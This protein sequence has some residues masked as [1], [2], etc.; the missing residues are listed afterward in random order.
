[1]DK[2][3]LLA[4]TLAIVIMLFYSIAMQ[5]YYPS[6]ATP[7]APASTESTKG[8]VSQTVSSETVSS[9]NLPK[10]SD[11]KT[12]SLQ[13]EKA[14]YEFSDLGGSLKSVNINKYNKLEQKTPELIYNSE[15]AKD[16]IFSV[17]GMGIQDGSKTV[18]YEYSAIDSGIEYTLRL[19]NG[20]EV[21]KIY[22]ADDNYGLTLELKFT[23]PAENTTRER[24][25]MVA[26]SNLKVL[27]AS[28]VRFTEAAFSF[29][30][31]QK[32]IRPGSINKEAKI[33]FGNA[34][35]AAIQGKY[36]SLVAKPYQPTVSLTISKTVS[37]PP[38]SNI[39]IELQQDIEIA[40]RSSTTHKFLLY[41]GP[42]NTDFMALHQS[43]IENSISYGVFGDISKFLLFLLNSFYKVSHNYGVSIILLALLISILLYPLTLKSLKSMKQMQA[44][45]PKVDKL[46]KELKDNPQK[47][48]KEMLELY[49]KYKVNPFGGCLPMLLQMPIFIAL[50]QAF[51]RAIELK[52]AKF[53]WI[54]DL[55]EPDRAFFLPLSGT[56]IPVNILPILMAI[57]M[58][59][60]Q[61]M[62][63][64][65]AR[66]A[67]KEDSIQQ[68]QKMMVIMMPIL[69]GFIFYNMPSGLVLYWFLNTVIMLIQQLRIKSSFHVETEGQA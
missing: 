67:D 48:N 16:A 51:I 50:Y 56:P 7:T 57:T 34:D 46:R 62:T 13:A 10:L 5:K 25:S 31:K 9:A 17:S 26:V 32:R 37:Q 41:S 47:L 29:G 1:M 64:S 54:K 28:D 18:S 14:R 30:A 6:P 53:L 24:Y 63:V 69:F 33:Y 23:N 20:L 8:T 42:N 59:V 40:P 19:A 11:Y 58:F 27:T 55:S 45:Q 36:F 22:R 43:G 4:I 52:N 12:R 66:V 35:W 2:R 61:K 49:K 60:Q 38:N 68:Q 44:L 3:T 21:K 65:P 39:S 15:F